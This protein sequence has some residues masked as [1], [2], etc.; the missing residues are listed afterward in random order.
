MPFKLGDRTITHT[1]Q[2]TSFEPRPFLDVIRLLRLVLMLK[3]LS[4]GGD[5]KG[6]VAGYVHGAMGVGMGKNAALVALKL[7]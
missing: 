4:L 1:S 3:V 6:V 5:G 7:G 2:L